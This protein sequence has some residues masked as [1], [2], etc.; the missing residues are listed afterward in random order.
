MGNCPSSHPNNIASLCYRN[1]PEGKEHVPGMPY[2]CRTK[3][4][5]SYTR[6]V[7]GIPGC[8]KGQVKDGALCYDDPG[9]GWRVVGGVAYQD[10]PEGSTDIGLF[11][12][13]GGSQLGIVLVGVL[14]TI[15][16]IVYFIRRLFFSA[17]TSTLS[18][19]MPYPQYPQYPPPYYGGKRKN[20]RVLIGGVIGLI[21]AYI[22]VSWTPTPVES[23][24]KE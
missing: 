7:G 6:G 2:L 22:L 12:I 10:C 3:G 15:L 5:A 24:T 11:C 1:C 23:S 8:P 20:S 14:F 18:S 21:V 19:A 9:P 17:A 16:P 4:D 13:P